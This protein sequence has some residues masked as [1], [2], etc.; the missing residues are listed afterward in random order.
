MPRRETRPR[1]TGG[2]AIGQ[3]LHR[4]IKQKRI[5]FDAIYWECG[6]LAPLLDAILG[7]RRIQLDLLGVSD[8]SDTEQRF[9]FYNKGLVLSRKQARDRS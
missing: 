3:P 2:L 8:F 4:G 1:A 9:D 7:Y 5:K 6:N